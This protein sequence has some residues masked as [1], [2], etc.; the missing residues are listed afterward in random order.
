MQTTVSSEDVQYAVSGQTL[1][2]QLAWNSERTT[3]GPGVLV[4]HEWWGQNDYARRRARNFAEAGYTALA[5]DLYGEGKCAATPDEAG[6]LMQAALAD[7]NTLRQR[8]EAAQTLLSDHAAVD[9]ERV[10][11]VGYCFGGAVALGMALHGVPLEGAAAC[12]PGDLPM[13]ASADPIGAKLWVGVGDA[14]PFVPAET[15]EKFEAAVRER[16]IPLEMVVYP[17]VQH[18][19]T[20]PEA[21][22][23]GQRFQLPLAYDEAADRDTWEAIQRLL[24]S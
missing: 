23:R 14:D 17:G 13:P 8:F 22:E 21:T 5:V 18:G 16:Q 9:P 3:P 2:G 7:P 6:A 20:V 19:Y 24:A 11:A 15:R 10:W 4:C 12:H 1:A